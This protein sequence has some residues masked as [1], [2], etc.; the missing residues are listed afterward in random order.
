MIHI[1]A[2]SASGVATF[3]GAATYGVNRPNVGA[4]L[5][6]QYSASGFW[7]AASLPS[8]LLHVIGLHSEY[9]DRNVPSLEN[10][11][12][13]SAMRSPWSPN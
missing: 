2:T 1:W 4:W 10:R 5:G 8:R 13:N 7:L 12:D 11:S 9:G 6:P 3:L